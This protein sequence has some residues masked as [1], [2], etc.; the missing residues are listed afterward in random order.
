MTVKR[1]GEK[2]VLKDGKVSCGCCCGCGFATP[3]NPISDPNFTKKLTGNDPSIPAFTQVSIN[4]NIAV[5]PAGS[6]SG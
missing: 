3:I 6:G 5:D 1:N 2:V 4:Y